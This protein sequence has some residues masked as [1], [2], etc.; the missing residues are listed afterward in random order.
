[1]N[2]YVY[3]D[4]QWVIIYVIS[5]ALSCT[6]WNNLTFPKM[7]DVSAKWEY[8]YWVE[9]VMIF[10]KEDVFG[11]LISNTLTNIVNL[12]FIHTNLICP[13]LYVPRKW[14]NTDLS[15]KA[16]RSVIVWKQICLDSST[17]F[18]VDIKEM[19]YRARP[20]TE[21]LKFTA[22]FHVRALLDRKLGLNLKRKHQNDFVRCIWDR[23]E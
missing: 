13:T 9:H 17:T 11:I 12:G 2:V 3:D 22:I 4:N 15:A 14:L 20:E 23:W 7:C 6:T 1:M 19:K 5:I 10:Q 16:G 18:G 8:K 21:Q